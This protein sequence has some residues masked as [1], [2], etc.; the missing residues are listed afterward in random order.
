MGKSTFSATYNRFRRLLVNAR[1]KKGFTQAD[2]AAKLAKPQ[3][4]VS[5]YELGERRLDVV[6]FLAVTKALG[7]DPVKLLK[8]LGDKGAPNNTR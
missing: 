4:F 3:S 2:V 6:E 7:V 8:Q 5:K 1:E